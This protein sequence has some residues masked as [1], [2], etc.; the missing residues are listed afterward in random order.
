MKKMDEN[1]RQIVSAAKRN[2]EERSTLDC[3]VSLE[4]LLLLFSCCLQNVGFVQRVY[5]L[6]PEEDKARLPSR[7]G[8]GPSY[9]ILFRLTW[10]EVGRRF[11]YTYRFDEVSLRRYPPSLKFEWFPCL[12]S[13]EV[14]PSG[15]SEQKHQR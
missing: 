9:S 10:F 15:L 7:V 12:P 13:R 5:P 14:I 8:S 2:L 1:N 4:A 6:N 11:E 3:V